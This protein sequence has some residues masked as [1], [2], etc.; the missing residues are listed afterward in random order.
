MVRFSQDWDPFEVSSSDN[1]TSLLFDIGV[2]NGIYHGAASREGGEDMVLPMLILAT[3]TGMLLLSG[4]PSTCIYLFY[5]C[6]I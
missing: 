3:R 5:S 2:S 4:L 1:C 6:Y